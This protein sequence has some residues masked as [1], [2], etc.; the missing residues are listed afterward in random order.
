MIFSNERAAILAVAALLLAAGPAPKPK[1]KGP[2][3]G[4]IERMPLPGGWLL[5]IAGDPEHTEVEVVGS[6]SERALLV[7]S[8]SSMDFKRLEVAQAALLDATGKTLRV[9]K[10]GG[11]HIIDASLARDGKSAVVVA[12]PWEDPEGKPVLFYFDEKGSTWKKSVTLGPRILVGGPWVALWIPPY[13]NAASDPGEDEMPK[14]Q[15]AEPVVLYRANGSTVKAG[16]IRGALARVGDGFA[17]VADSKLSLYGANLTRLKEVALP[18]RVGMPFAA[19]NGSLIAVGDYTESD[20]PVRTLV[21]FDGDAKKLGE[22][23]M[24][25]AYGVE[26]AIAPD[27]SALLAAS[28]TIGRKGPVM[29]SEGAPQISIVMADRTGKQLWKYT[30]KPRS[31]TEH[32]ASLSVSARGRRACVGMKAIDDQRPDK[33]LIFDER[34]KVIYKAEGDFR[35]AWLDASGKWLWTVETG[36]L[37]RLDVDKVVAGTAFPDDVASAIPVTEEDLQ[38][39]GEPDPNAPDETFPPDAPGAQE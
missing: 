29:A 31:A 18:F 23:K 17:A 38:D 27:G 12:E 26:A 4:A 1:P 7:T 35:D 37:S 34:G 3:P 16:E 6:P 28:A 25:A 33:L 2:P 22:I 36:G 8:I 15:V 30:A 39:E 21:I 13:V 9:Q 5:Q 10:V 11:H 24:P 14:A 19:D 20:L 32:F